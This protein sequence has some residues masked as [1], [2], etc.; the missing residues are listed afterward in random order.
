CGEV[1]KRLQGRADPIILRKEIERLIGEID[2][3]QYMEGKSKIKAKIENIKR[4]L[5]EITVKIESEQAKEKI[6]EIEEELGKLDAL[7]SRMEELEN[8][9]LSKTIRRIEYQRLKDTNEKTYNRIIRR[10]EAKIN[11]LTE[12]KI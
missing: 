5:T 9:K 12:I 7:M 1:Q 2:R 3:K 11:E 10:I 4:K 8:K 6:K